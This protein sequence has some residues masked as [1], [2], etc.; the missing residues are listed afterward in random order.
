MSTGLRVRK[1][2]MGSIYDGV[3]IMHESSAYELIEESGMIK[4]A[5]KNLL[6]VGRKRLGA[7]DESIVE[8]LKAIT[9]LDRLDQL[10]EALLNASSWKEL[11][12]TP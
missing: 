6:Q 5:Q 4:Y 11:L 10:N 8:A 12:A 1:E 2:N 7:P 3:R 9:N